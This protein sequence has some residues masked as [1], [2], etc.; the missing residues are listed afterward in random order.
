MAPQKDA[1]P[2]P[3]VPSSG[4]SK[5]PPRAQHFLSFMQFFGNFGKIICWR[6]LVRGILD[7][8]GKWINIWPFCTS[9]TCKTHSLLNIRYH[10]LGH[11]YSCSH[12]FLNQKILLK[13]LTLINALISKRTIFSALA[14]PRGGGPR[15]APRV[16]FLLVFG[17]NLA[18]Y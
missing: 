7:P 2:L 5:A 14:D 15:D 3:P 10:N 9:I 1:H 13:S 8:L 17:K 16:Q 18:R 12:L 6:S 4:Q 11:F